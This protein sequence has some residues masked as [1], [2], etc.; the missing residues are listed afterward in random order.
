MRI[1]NNSTGGEYKEIGPG[2]SKGGK[3]TQT[4]SEWSNYF[5]DRLTTILESDILLPDDNSSQEETDGND[6]DA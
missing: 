3:P 4:M 6:Y 2:N 1:A 5:A